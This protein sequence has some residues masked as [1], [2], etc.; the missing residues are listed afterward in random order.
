[1]LDEMLR[2]HVVCGINNSTIQKRLLAEP[3][4]MLTKAVAV[5]QATEIAD[6][7][8]KELQSSTATASSVFPRKT[9]V[10]TNL[11]ILPQL[12]LQTIPAKSRNVIVVVQSTTLISVVSGQRSAMTVVSKATLP[13][14]VEVRRKYRLQ[15]LTVVL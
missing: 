9:K 12:S 3:K 7:G 1:M 8:V 2:D 6:T 4:L 13:E 11:L 14:F 5:A 15:R 10:H